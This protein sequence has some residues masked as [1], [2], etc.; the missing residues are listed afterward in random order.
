MECVQGEGSYFVSPIDSLPILRKICGKHLILLIVD[1]I[2]SGFGHTG[3]MFATQAF[4]TQP[5]IL[6]V[7]EA[8]EN[9]YLLSATIASKELISHWYSGL[10]GQV[11][12]FMPPLNVTT[13]QV[14]QALHIL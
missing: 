2:Q 6:T 8:I 14:H 7:A 9:G 12:R 5:D 1:E 10:H 3:Q 13:E 11:I 4:N